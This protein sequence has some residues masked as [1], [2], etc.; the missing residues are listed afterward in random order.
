MQYKWTW[1]VF[2]L[3]S[4]V[5]TSFSDPTVEVSFGCVDSS[6]F[7]SA[8]VD[9]TE[10]GISQINIDYIVVP[11]KNIPGNSNNSRKRIAK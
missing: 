5:K 6:L 1:K 11:F 7:V 8:N 2:I 9:V 10:Q 3:L 4:N